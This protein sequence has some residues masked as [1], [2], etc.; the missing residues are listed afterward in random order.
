MS[1]PLRLQVLLVVLHE[2]NL[3][4]TFILVFLYVLKN[5]MFIPVF[6]CWFLSRHNRQ[7]YFSL[8]WEILIPLSSLDPCNQSEISLG[9]TLHRCHLPSCSSTY[10]QMLL[11]STGVL[12]LHAIP[13]LTPCW[14]PP[15]HPMAVFP[16]S[17]SLHIA[18]S[19]SLP[20]IGSNNVYFSVQE[21]ASSAKAVISY[22]IAF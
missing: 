1:R 11:Y 18:H 12:E 3:G 19:I 22:H 15:L 17:H 21:I 13:T 10:R 8:T 14:C 5:R 9:A 6:P 4:N 7:L 20:N 16:S 2:A